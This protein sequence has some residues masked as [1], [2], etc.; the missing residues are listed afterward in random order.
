MMVFAQPRVKRRTVGIIALLLG[1]TCLACYLLAPYCATLSRWLPFASAISPPWGPTHHDSGRTAALAGDVLAAPA[2]AS[3]G[4][5]TP[6]DLHSSAAPATPSSS[7]GAAAAAAGDGSG[8]GSS[9]S[10]SASPSASVDPTPHPT[11][12][13]P[14][15]EPSTSSPSPQPTMSSPSAKPSTPAFT[16][17]FVAGTP[18]SFAYTTQSGPYT[19]GAQSC[20]QSGVG[21]SG[22]QHGSNTSCTYPAYSTGGLSPILAGWAMWQNA[23]GV[24]TYA[25]KAEL[26]R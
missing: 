19:S 22:Y 7:A 17:H 23:S 2:K 1:C 20:A 24:C 9:H 21:C 10:R 26:H 6:T 4:R 3:P 18:A 11:T 13:T 5:A 16:P 12:S 8:S 14:S 25:M 15:P